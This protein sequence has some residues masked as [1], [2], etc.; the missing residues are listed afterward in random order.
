MLAHELVQEGHHHAGRHGEAL[1]LEDL[2]AD[3][4]IEK[5]GGKMFGHRRQPIL[6]VAGDGIVGQELQLL[7]SR[8]WLTGP[9]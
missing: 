7:T 8:H 4:V 2:G 9:P 5:F 1:K 6:H 3:L